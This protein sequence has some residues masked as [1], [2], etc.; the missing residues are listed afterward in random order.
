MP[1]TGSVYNRPW[2]FVDQR[3]K[4][5]DALRSDFDLQLDDMAYAL[6]VAL[7]GSVNYVGDWDPASGEFP[8]ER[9]SGGVIRAR[10]AWVVV[11]AGE[12][13]GVAFVA[14]STLL[15]VVDGPGAVYAENWLRLEFVTKT[16][17]DGLAEEIADEAQAARDARDLSA[18]W[19][20]SE[21]AE[22]G[23][24]GTKSAKEWAGE[25]SDRAQEA[26]DFAD[27]ADLSAQQAAA[28]AAALGSPISIANGGTGATDAA[29]ARANLGVL[30]EPPDSGI[31]VRLSTG[32][33]TTRTLT[34]TPN[35]IFVSNGIG[36]FGNPT[37]SAVIASQAEAQAGSDNVKLMTALRTADAIAARAG[38]V[39]ASGNFTAAT[40]VD[41][42]L[43]AG[44]F[45]VE[46]VLNISAAS[47]ID[48][49]VDLQMTRDGFTSVLSGASDYRWGAATLIFGSVAGTGLVSAADSK[50]RVTPV[51]G[52]SGLNT[53]P[54]AEIRVELGNYGADSGIKRTLA[55]GAYIN[56][57]G[58]LSF[59][60]AS[61]GILTAA[62][63][64]SAI[65]GLRF[66][67]S[68]GTFTG[69][70]TVLARGKL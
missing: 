22:P 54:N 24:P 59:L 36:F 8:T 50:I 25:A 35:Q 67:P 12:V 41:I 39:V 38:G 5:D 14:G 37:I 64:T 60:Y 15:A 40:A 26:S 66:F 56:A 17:L 1:L 44:W 68:S 7:T 13:G 34:G 27:A 23:G 57:I 48:T 53:T 61:S 30:P 62:D 16:D 20:E 51:T 65:N 21:D 18:Q 43:P 4:G 32:A 69:T 70:Y 11:G 58:N 42:A 52:N 49:A 29:T 46:I 2:K 3:Q 63:P 33:A 55:R 45:D 47:V 6:N 31:M 10:D 28:S 19:A 9:P